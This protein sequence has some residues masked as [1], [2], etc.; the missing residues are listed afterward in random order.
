M[1]LFKIKIPV[2]MCIVHMAY[3]SPTLDP[4]E[5]N[6]DGELWMAYQGLKDTNR[7][8]VHTRAYKYSTYIH[9]F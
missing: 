8:A 2:L 4:H 9:L 5:L 3:R 7:S 6:E 1:H